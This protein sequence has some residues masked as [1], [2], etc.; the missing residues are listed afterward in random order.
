GQTLAG[1]F[2]RSG[3]VDEMVIY[4]A[5]C[6]L[7]KTAQPLLDLVIDELAEG[8]QLAYVSVSRLGADLRII[9]SLQPGN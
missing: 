2:V 8:I 3:L 9:A 4:Q 1:A 5:P 6:L 7:G